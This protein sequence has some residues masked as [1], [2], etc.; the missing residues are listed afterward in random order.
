VKV[1]DTHDNPH[2]CSS[3]GQAKPTEEHVD[4]GAAWDGP[5]YNQ[6]EVAVEGATP[7]QI[8]DLKVCKTCILDAMKTLQMQ[9]PRD[10]EHELILQIEEQKA[11]NGG[12]RG[13]LEQ[14][15]RALQVKPKQKARA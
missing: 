5:V 2:R 6:L 3:C 12:Q 14:L 4:F 7:M 13:Y 11:L 9:I 10:R 8:D 15:E 1:C